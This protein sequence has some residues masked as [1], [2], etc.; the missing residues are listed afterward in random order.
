MRRTTSACLRG[1][2]ILISAWCFAQQESSSSLTIYNQNFA[3][4]RQSVPLELKAGINHVV[5]SNITAHVEP[6]SVVLR[7]LGGGHLQ[8]LEQ[9][10]VRF[11]E[12]SLKRF[13][14]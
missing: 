10:M 1:F 8:I 3:V 6:E 7:D 4:V 14:S 5:F 12:I 11:F 2:V 13:E 9:K